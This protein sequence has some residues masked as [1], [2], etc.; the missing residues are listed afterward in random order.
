[1]H[2]EVISD[3]EGICLVILF[4]SGSTLAMPTG[5]AAGRDLWLAILFAIV[6]AIP[7][8]LIYAKLLSLFLGKDLFDILE[9]GFGKIIGKGIGILFI[10]FAFHL[11]V[12]SIRNIGEFPVTVSLPET[13]IP[14]FTLSMIMLAIWIVKEGIEVLGRWANIFVLFNAPIP[15]MII[16]M[17]I[18]IMDINNIQPILYDGINPLLKGTFEAFAFPFAETVLF[19]MIVSSLKTKKSSYNIYIKGL[20]LGGM[21]ILGVSLTEVLV[22]GPD[23]YGATFFPNHVVARK[24]DIGET[25]QRMEVIVILA[26]TTASFLKMSVCLLAV[27]N[28]IAKI[29]NLDDY[30]GFVT[31]IGLLMFNF[32]IFIYKSIN[33]MT[34]WAS[35][36]WPYYA[37]LFQVILPIVLFIVV[38]IKRNSVST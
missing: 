9:Y 37:F 33:E 18:P 3:R 10:W 28:G 11:G 35:S 14:I 21:L 31:P 29:F 7:I 1:M 12:L 32:A 27:C 34:M 15:S 13:P 16:L 4:I 8:L 5:A 17:L 6:I 24:V 38:M 22:L 36:I 23:L 19:T 20:L 2:K 25:L 30:R 26:T